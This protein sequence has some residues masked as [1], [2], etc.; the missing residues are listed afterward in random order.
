MAHTLAS[1]AILLS[2]LTSIAFASDTW[3]LNCGPL[4]QARLDPIDQPG[5]WPSG[6]VHAAVGSTAFAMDMSGTNGAL[7]GKATTCDKFTDHSSYWAPQLYHM[8]QDGRLDLLPF[9]GMV[10][11]YENYTC[12][13][14]KDSPGV[15]PGVRDAMAFPAGLKMLAGDSRRRTLNMSDQWQQAILLE[16]GNSGE[17]YGMPT[18]LDGTRLSGHA[19]FP[20]CWDG[21][22]LDSDDHQSHVAYPDASLGGNTQGGMCPASHPRAM[23]N[24]GAEFGWNL[25]GITD[26]ASLVFANGDTTGYGFHADFYMGWENRTALKESFATCLSNDDCPWR[27]FGSPNGENPNP[28]ARNPQQAPPYENIGQNG[29]IAKLPGDNPV[30]KPLPGR[31]HRR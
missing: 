17:V 3:T 4:V 23:I 16:A 21:Q 5:V 19:R 28:T 10:A 6:H 15:C 7:N 29:P 9:T 20:S 11:Y 26:P 25:N 27:S 13:Y 8:R 30:Y 14:N 31:F 18:T 1:L 2:T 12:S 24:V 22:H